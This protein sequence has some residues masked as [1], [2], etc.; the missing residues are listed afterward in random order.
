MVWV[1]QGWSGQVRD[2]AH[3]VFRDQRVDRP[4]D[5]T[6]N[7]AA[8][9]RDASA[10]DVQDLPRVVLVDIGP[11]V[12]HMEQPGAYDPSDDRPDGRRVNSIGVHALQWGPPAHQYDGAGHGDE[13]EEAVPAHHPGVHEV[14][15]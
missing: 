4:P 9:N 13:A 6:S 14:R 1:Q 8:P 15:R 5:E 12:D 3:R 11:V 7:D 2:G 10:G